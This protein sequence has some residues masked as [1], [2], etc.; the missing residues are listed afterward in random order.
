MQYVLLL[1]FAVIVCAAVLID[2]WLDRRASKRSEAAETLK[3][4]RG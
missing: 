4:L 3:S 2:W 1:F